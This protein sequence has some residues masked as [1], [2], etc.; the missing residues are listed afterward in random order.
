M[1]EELRNSRDFSL[2]EGVIVMTIYNY[3]FYKVN[4][5]NRETNPKSLFE[6]QKGEKISYMQYYKEKYIYIK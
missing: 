1:Y 3:K 5:V 2:L 4:R 6:N